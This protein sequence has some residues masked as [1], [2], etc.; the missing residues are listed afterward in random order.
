MVISCYMYFSATEITSFSFLK[1]SL[2]VYMLFI[3]LSCLAHGL[4]HSQAVSNSVAI[5]TIVHLYLWCLEQDVVCNGH[6]QIYFLF[7][8]VPPRSFPQWLGS[9]AFPLA[10]P[11]N[12]F[13]WH[14]FQNV[15]PFVFMM[16][17]ILSWVRENW[18]LKQLHTEFVC[19]KH[20]TFKS[21]WGEQC[22]KL[23]LSLDDYVSIM[24]N[25]RGLVF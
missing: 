4:F 11:A 19:Q 7:C 8:E 23:V 5:N 14:P 16:T 2:C 9:S 10:G 22:R 21:Q 25:Q 15:W 18:E 12:P 6:T 13:C 3:H 24:L 17:A 1:F 20:N